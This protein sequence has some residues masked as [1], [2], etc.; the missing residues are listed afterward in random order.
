MMTTFI[1]NDLC[2]NFKDQIKGGVITW[3]GICMVNKV[4]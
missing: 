4:E 3:L 1:I 2:Q